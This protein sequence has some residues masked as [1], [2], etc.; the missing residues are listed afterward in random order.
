[1]KHIHWK[2]IEVIAFD[3]VIDKN[4]SFLICWKSSEEASVICFDFYT[5]VSSVYFFKNIYSLLVLC[6]LAYKWT[7]PVLELWIVVT[8]PRLYAL[9]RINLWPWPPY[10]L[11]Q[12]LFEERTWKRTSNSIHHSLRVFVFR[13]KCSCQFSFKDGGDIF[14]S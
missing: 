12:S 10:V 2:P 7:F 4:C 13:Q 11:L 6:F 3:L 14:F 5:T 8:S 9:N 1:M